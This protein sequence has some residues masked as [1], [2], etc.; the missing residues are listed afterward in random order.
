[1]RLCAKI[2]CDVCRDRS[3]VCRE[4]SFCAMKI[5]GGH[6]HKTEGRTD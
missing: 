2:S 4:P 6:P 3:R 1:M 5:E